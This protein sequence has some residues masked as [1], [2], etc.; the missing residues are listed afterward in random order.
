MI[1]II[2]QFGFTIAIASWTNFL[3]KIIYQMSCVGEA[4]A[5]KVRL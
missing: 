2:S 1:V 3:L 5:Y 4:G